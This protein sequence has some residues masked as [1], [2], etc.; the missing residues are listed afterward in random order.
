MSQYPNAGAGLKQMFIAQVGAIICTVCAIIPIINIIA[1]IGA[2][3]F[4]VISLVGLY[5][6][7]KDIE[8]CK[9]AFILSIVGGIVNLLASLLAAVPVVG[10]LLSIAHTIISLL[11]VYFVCTCQ[12]GFEP[13]RCD[14]CRRYG[15]GR[16]EIESG[17]LCGFDRVQYSC[18]DSGFGSHWITH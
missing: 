4:V 17:L 18:D 10:S 6:L 8:E 13:D 7:G 5:N 15:A 1:M 14:R 12:Q 16:V 9:I 3:V 2:I 11:A